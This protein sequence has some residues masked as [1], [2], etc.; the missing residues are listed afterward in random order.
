MSRSTQIRQ[1]VTE[2]EQ[3]ADVAVEASYDG[4]AQRWTL[5]W[6]NGPTTATMRTHLTGL[7]ERAGLAVELF[8]LS[9]IIQDDALALQAVRYL[10]TTRPGQDFS[11]ST[12]ALAGEI[13]R[14]AR[15]SDHPDRPRDEREAVLAQRLLAAEGG[16]TTPQRLAERLLRPGHGLAAL[17]ENDLHHVRPGDPLWAAEY[18][19]AHYSAAPGNQHG[20]RDDDRP[21]DGIGGGL[22]TAEQVRAW[23]RHLQT[24]PAPT[25]LAAVAT[26]PEAGP[27]A[28]IA[29]LTLASP[30][31]AEL[32]AMLAD[33]DHTELALIT[34]LRAG[35]TAWAQIGRAL[36]TTR[37]GAAQ[38]ADR[39]TTRTSPPTSTR[40]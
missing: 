37:Q 17:L 15:D 40:H 35:G 34:G 18:L 31:R 14:A 27:I 6:D 16:S 33:H 25:L 30:I 3:A 32:E 29:A 1:L 24:A 26:D 5:H 39:L 10:R 38:R 12:S 22:G 20:D 19:T 8:E 9:R 28:R 2:L 13:E 36:G 23:Q 4:R 11:T 21:D 7:A